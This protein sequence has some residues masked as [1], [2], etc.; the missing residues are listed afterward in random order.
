M[1]LTAGVGSLSVSGNNA[2]LNTSRTA[3]TGSLSVSG[4][5]ID[6]S[7]IRNLEAQ[8][9]RIKA[10]FNFHYRYIDG[11]PTF[12]GSSAGLTYTAAIPTH[13]A[14]DLIVVFALNSNNN[15]IPVAPTGEGWTSAHSSS[16]A[17]PQPAGWRIGFKYAKGN[18]E[19][20][21][22]WFPATRI[23]VAVYRNARALVGAATQDVRT[24]ANSIH[25]PA[26][27]P[28]VT[29]T[30]GTRLLRLGASYGSDDS[31][32]TTTGHTTRIS[33][34]SLSNSGAPSISIKDLEVPPNT[35][36]A[37]PAIS[38]S[39]G[40]TTKTIGI[41]L[42][43]GYGTPPLT[44]ETESFST[45]LNGDAL[46]RTVLLGSKGYRAELGQVFVTYASLFSC[47]AGAFTLSG[48]DLNL[49]RGFF[50]QTGSEGYSYSL[51][52]SLLA[53]ALQLVSQ[54]E[55]F[56]FSGL[57]VDLP[58][59]FFT[60]PGAGAF[61]S[62]TANVG[63]TL[64]ARLAADRYDFDANANEAQLQRAL[65]EAFSSSSLSFSLSQ[66]GIRDITASPPSG[67]PAKK[68]AS[69][70]GGSDPSG[71]SSLRP[72]FVKYNSV[73]KSR[74]LGSVD[75][76]YGTFTGD[77]GSEVGSP[78]LFFKMHI[79]GEAILRVSKNASNRYTD[80]QISVGVLDANRKQVL[81]DRFGY[82][83]NNDNAAT[84]EDESLAPLPGGTYYFT[85][86]S[87]QWQ[88]I[89]YSVSIQAIRYKSVKGVATLS[90]LPTSRFAIAKLRGPALLTNAS[91]GT[92]PVHEKIKSPTGQ[93][94]LT[95]SS[96]GTLV[97]PEGVAVMRNAT[98]GRLKQT[99]KLLAVAALTGA[100][101][102]TLSSQPPTGGGY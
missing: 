20:V 3:G 68:P 24:S 5:D 80:K 62:S 69:E 56:S 34:E 7:S 36:N 1:S 18:N 16:S 76:F 8:P 42:G 44:A 32:S 9:G 74:D 88:K 52:E 60:T 81:I 13:Q 92:I 23:V 43:I 75:N 22:N 57:S 15:T 48:S 33:T 85:V 50:L 37:Y 100:N 51:S 101:V 77:I 97:T 65:I 35:S 63:A 87:S 4:N 46:A 72:Q 49:P 54:T 58:K 64:A 31:G 95:S 25:Y 102:A 78:T 45:T 17:A 38:T 73:S 79:Q 29:G 26:A 47:S 66:V 94:L 96:Q 61:N 93:A 83:F 84:S 59:G 99:H 89:P 82:A 40:V 86:S 21:G 39:V 28:L 67:G 55:S 2:Q 91:A 11:Y 71:P 98:T 90:M 70:Y 27:D 10:G 19:T 12:V 14:H 41:T 53:R 30:A 6:F